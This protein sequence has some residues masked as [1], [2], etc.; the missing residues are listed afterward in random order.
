MCVITANSNNLHAQNWYYKN[1]FSL[2]YYEENSFKRL[3]MLCAGA[4][5]K[6]PLFIHRA[7]TEIGD[8]S[9][10]VLFKADIICD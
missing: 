5:Y 8:S 6:W 2:K 3:P 4:M 7:C 9:R 10:T 1:N